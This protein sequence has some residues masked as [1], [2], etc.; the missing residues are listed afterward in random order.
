MTLLETLT[1]TG[2]SVVSSTIPGTYKDLRLIVRN[3]LP[4]SNGFNLQVRINGETGSKYSSTQTG[5]QLYDSAPFTE[6]AWYIALQQNNT[7]STGLS[8]VLI[9]DYANT[10]TRKTAMGNGIQ[11][12]ETNPTTKISFFTYKYAFD[13]TS[14]ITS[15]TFAATSGNLTSGSVLIYGVK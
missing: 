2:S 1:L 4:A 10:T 7:T 9:P 6:T 14:A 13:S 8:D 5:A 15:L 12:F 3:Y 11:N